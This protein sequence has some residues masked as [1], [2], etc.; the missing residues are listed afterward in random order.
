MAAGITFY[1]VFF[2]PGVLKNTGFYVDDTGSPTQFRV[3]HVLYDGSGNIASILS[4]GQQKNTLYDSAGAEILGVKTDAANTAVDATA[5]SFM[6]VAKQLSTSLQALQNNVTSGGP[7]PATSGA[8]VTPVYAGIL[9]RNTYPIIDSTDTQIVAAG[10]TNVRHYVTG[11]MMANTGSNGANVDMELD[12]AAGSEIIT[13]PVPAAVTAGDG[14]GVVYNFTH[15]LRAATANAAIYA[16]AA[17]TSP[18]DFSLVITV[19]GYSVN[20]S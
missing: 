15:P 19:F 7:K 10:G 16:D 18:S 14:A 20:E 13:L 4:N 3:A 5:V 17:V 11:I 1:P 12:G 9:G 6:Q 8:P 2:S